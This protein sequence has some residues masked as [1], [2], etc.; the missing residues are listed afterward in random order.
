M[1]SLTLSACGGSAGNTEDTV[2]TA[3]QT[4]TS[5]PGAS[6]SQP[7]AGVKPCEVFTTEQATKL[8]LNG[9]G[10]IN[11]F[12]DSTCGWKLGE[13]ILGVSVYKDMALGEINFSGDEKTQTTFQ[14]HD[15]L[16]VR[17][18][19]RQCSLAF[20]ISDATSMLVRSTVDVSASPDTACKLVKKAAPMVEATIFDN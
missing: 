16:L 10:T 15:A 14:G 13:H 1:V 19:E 6:N 8:G 3:R 4:A 5:E 17:P 2:N 7:L 20:A 12:D 18:N 9:P 11:E